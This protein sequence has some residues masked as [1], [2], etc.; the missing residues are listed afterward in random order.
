[1]VFSERLKL[2]REKRNWSQNELAEKIHISRQSVSKWETGRNYPSIET[3]IALS[4]L[5]DITIDELLKNDDELKEKVIQD[6]KKLEYPKL[7]MFFDIVFSVGTLLL[8]IKLAILIINKLLTD[9]IVLNGLS[10]IV[11]NFLPLIL[12]IIGRIGSDSLKNKYI[13]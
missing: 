5:F 9:I 7:K 12:M 8:L 2:E 3:I 1:M 11:L 13:S 10:S 6:G 4:D